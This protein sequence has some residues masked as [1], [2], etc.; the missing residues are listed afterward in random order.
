MK[1]LKEIGVS[2]T[3]NDAGKFSFFADIKLTN[4]MS[5]KGLIKLCLF[6]E[7]LR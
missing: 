3:L 2:V 4:G 6:Q 5:F 7:G 1:D